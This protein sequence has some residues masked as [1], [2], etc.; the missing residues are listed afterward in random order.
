MKIPSFINTEKLQ[1]A[2]KEI[3]LNRLLSYGLILS[4]IPLCLIFCN[5]WSQS[6]SLNEI[7]HSFDRIEQNLL[8][9]G[10]RQANNLAVH[11]HYLNADHFYIDKQLETLRFLQPE[12][13]ELNSLCKKKE[14][15][16]T[17]HLVKRLEIL[18]SSANRLQF[19]EG[20]I[21]KYPSFQ[22]TQESLTHS[23]EVETADL[24]RILSAI[25]GEE[26]A[27]LSV[28]SDIPQFLITDFKI[29]KKKIRE[30]KEV[31]LLNLKFL[32]R[33]YFQKA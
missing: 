28:A 19:T 29:E 27:K 30:N 32:K 24:Q 2:V 6:S 3:P 18:N 17:E 10:R 25:E 15:A 23:I 11:N 7:K 33:E 8:T 9:Q 26:I 13:E 5:Y 20:A 22:E 1:S 31:F 4:L 21:Q 12:V 14:I 16:K